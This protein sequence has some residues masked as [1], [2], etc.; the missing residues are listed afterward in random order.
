MRSQVVRNV[1]AIYNAS[2]RTSL[3][4]NGYV[5]EPR[6]VEAVERFKQRIVWAHGI[7]IVDRMRYFSYGSIPRFLVGNSV[8]GF[9]KR[10]ASCIPVL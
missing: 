4:E 9:G 7:N 6:R 10:N 8:H 5:L 1:S 3:I 2:E